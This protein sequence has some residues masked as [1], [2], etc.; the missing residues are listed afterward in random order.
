MG[1]DSVR[2][3]ISLAEFLKGFRV[4]LKSRFELFNLRDTFEGI[5]QVYP[6]QIR[7]KQNLREESDKGNEQVP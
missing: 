7:N 6:Y 2:S 3:K 4:Q 5:F 1:I